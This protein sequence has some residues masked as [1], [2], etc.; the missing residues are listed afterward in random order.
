MKLYNK[1]NEFIFSF[2][3][4]FVVKFTV[5]SFNYYEELNSL[6]YLM[7]G[8]YRNYKYNL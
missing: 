6:K 1:Y 4:D 3:N 8:N 5:Q 7:K 2:L